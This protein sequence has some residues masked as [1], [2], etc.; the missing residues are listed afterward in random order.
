MFSDAGYKTLI[1]WN[2]DKV[3]ARYADAFESLNLSLPCYEW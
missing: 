2:E 3:E 1:Q